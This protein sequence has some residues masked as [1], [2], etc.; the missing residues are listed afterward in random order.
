VSISR[1][2]GYG[3][4]RDDEV[5]VRVRP[6][7]K[8]GKGPPAF[9]DTRTS[10]HVGVALALVM[11]TSF[12]AYWIAGFPEDLPFGGSIVVVNIDPTS[13]SLMPRSLSMMRGELVAG[14]WWFCTNVKSPI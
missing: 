6:V 7:L 4:Q 13:Q 1:C 14:V 3:A 8:R 12:I 2:T 11:M 5:W 9:E 10:F